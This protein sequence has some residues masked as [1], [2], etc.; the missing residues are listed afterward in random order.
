MAL[1]SCRMPDDSPI[2]DDS[3]PLDDSRISDNAALA[4]SLQIS[5]PPPC[6]DWAK[7]QH[8]DPIGSAGYYDGFLLVEQ[9]LPWPADVSEMPELAE[10]AKVAYGARLRLQAWLGH[11]ARGSGPAAEGRAKKRHGPRL[12]TMRASA[13]QAH[14]LPV[15]AARVGG[16]D[17]SLRATG[18]A[19]VAGRGGASRGGSSCCRHRSG[20]QRCRCH[21]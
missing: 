21:C 19:R 20:G 16:P 17:G 9:P 1:V 18:G 11:E 15:N 12:P 3:R 2:T 5:W 4:G 10:V 8:L 6:S 13:S 7:S 14:L